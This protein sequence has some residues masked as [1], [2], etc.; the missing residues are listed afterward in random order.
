MPLDLLNLKPAIPRRVATL[1]PVT[2]TLLIWVVLETRVPCR[3]LF[4]RVPYYSGD[5][6]FRELHISQRQ[7]S[8]E[9]RGLQTVS[10]QQQT[11]SSGL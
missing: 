7:C 10:Q 9:F 6:E 3:V 4:R 2:S 11:G 1:L 8:Q 5:L